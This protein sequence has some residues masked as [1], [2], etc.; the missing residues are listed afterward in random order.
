MS[1]DILAW[2]IL[3]NTTN[4]VPIVHTLVFYAVSSYLSFLSAAFS[5]KAISQSV[6]TAR[7]I[8]CMECKNRKLA[9]MFSPF[10]L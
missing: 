1:S 2:V 9:S 6:F 10:P 3:S 4:T 5:G 7:L 8:D